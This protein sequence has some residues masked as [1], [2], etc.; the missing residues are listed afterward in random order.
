MSTLKNVLAK[1]ALTLT[2]SINAALAVDSYNDSEA[3]GVENNQC[4]IGTLQETLPGQ[5]TS[6]QTGGRCT[7][8]LP[9]HAIVP[10]YA[11]I[12]G[13]ACVI[14]LYLQFH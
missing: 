11:E 3:W 10:A 6:F 2:I 5:C 9:S 1:L 7:V 12:S 4:K 8:K 14:P 13:L